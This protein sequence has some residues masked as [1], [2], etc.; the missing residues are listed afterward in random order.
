MNTLSKYRP[1]LIWTI[2]HLFGLIL[3]YSRIS[4]RP[5]TNEFWPFGTFSKRTIWSQQIAE[6]H[7]WSHFGF[8]ASYDWFE[9]LIYVGSPLIIICLINLGNY[10]NPKGEQKTSISKT[11]NQT[12]LK[13]KE[14]VSNSEIDITEKIEKLSNLR[15][16]GIITESEFLD[17]KTDLLNR[18]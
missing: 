7:S 4:G 18:L 9:F 11:N 3:S 2:L 15:D 12:D 13:L 16:K 6:E 10:K 14:S 1:F 17:K 8:F 5:N